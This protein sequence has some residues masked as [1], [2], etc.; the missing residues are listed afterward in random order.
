[1]HEVCMPSAGVHCLFLS[2]QPA[3]Q[4]LLYSLNHYKV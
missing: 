1:M 3:E 2:T 4:K